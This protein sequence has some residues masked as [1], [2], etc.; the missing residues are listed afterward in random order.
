MEDKNYSAPSQPIPIR[1][2]D[3]I[4]PQPS[5]P[6]PSPQGYYSQ[7]QM[8]PQ[9]SQ[10]FRQ[11]GE[12]QPQPNQPLSSPQGYYPQNQMMSQLGSRVPKCLSCG[13]VTQWNVE[14]IFLP[15]HFV[16]GGLLFFFFGGGLVYLLLVAIIRSGSKYRAKICPVCKARNL[17]S[18]IY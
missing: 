1:R 16:V 3:A 5:Q 4:Q 2:H 12:I 15:R 10:P 6:L 9:P 14:P 13:T 7:S 18:F 8:T 17:W 11:H